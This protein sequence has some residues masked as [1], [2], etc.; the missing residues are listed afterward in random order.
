MHQPHLYKFCIWIF[1]LSFH[2]MD[3]DVD[4]FIGDGILKCFQKLNRLNKLCII[5]LI[6][7]VGTKFVLLMVKWHNAYLTH[8]LY[9]FQRNWVLIH[10]LYLN[11][12]FNAIW[13]FGSPPLKSTFC[14]NTEWF[15]KIKVHPIFK[16]SSVECDLWVLRSRS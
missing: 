13:I 3:K 2:F 11:G 7:K 6:L 16:K 8:V 14:L 12:T 4:L 1:N 10:F 5:S 9:N 15:S